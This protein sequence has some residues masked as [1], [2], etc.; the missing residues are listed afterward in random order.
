MMS[1]VKGFHAE[2]CRVR[3]VPREPQGLRWVSVFESPVGRLGVLHTGR[4]LYAAEF[5]AVEGTAAA[6]ALP[7]AEM[8]PLPDWINL[9]LEDLFAGRPN[10]DWAVVDTGFTEL[11][12]ALLK[13]AA[14]IPFGSTCSYATLA[15]LAGFPGRARAAGRAMS[16]AP[17]AYFIPTHRIIRADGTAAECQRDPLNDQLRHFEGIDLASKGY[18]KSRRYSP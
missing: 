13:T 3:W 2:G 6:A 16:R 8:A 14:E 12:K 10:S 17:L 7:G 15:Y 9:V 11:E 4:A 1:Q 5:Q 18:S